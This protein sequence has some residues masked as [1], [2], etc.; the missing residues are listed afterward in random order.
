MLARARSHAAVPAVAGALLAYLVAISLNF[1]WFPVTAPFWILLASA[2]ALTGDGRVVAMHHGA[3]A[4]ARAAVATLAAGL[5]GLGLWALVVRP[6][7]ADAFYARALSAWSAGHRDSALQAIALARAADGGQS[8]YAATQGDLEDD[9]D[10]E[11][12][13]PR[14]D[15]RAARAAYE[16]ALAD[17][18]IRPAVALRLAYVDLALGDARGALAAARTAGA[19]DPYGPALKL[20][21]E[22][23]G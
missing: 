15:L 12:P 14:A 13:G 7:L 6:A 19:L 21:A 3:P 22:L 17:G 16:A 9:L 5:V 20:I 4:A 18:D 11:R 1:A 10:G 23:G 2:A 8:E